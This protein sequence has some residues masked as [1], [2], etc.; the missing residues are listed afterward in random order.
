MPKPWDTAAAL[1]P[2]SP[3]HRW[4]NAAFWLVLSVAAAVYVIS[5]VYVGLAQERV[6]LS[7][8]EARCDYRV[9]LV[10][11]RLVT[12]LQQSRPPGHPSAIA[13]GERLSTLL[14][15]TQAMCSAQDSEIGRKIDRISAIFD[16][17]VDRSRRD[18]ENRQELLGL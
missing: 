2:P 13:A 3:S 5:G 8:T 15:E 7:R 16:A 4:I 12:L 14:H 17:Y 11:D 9:E 6:G 10:R 1:N 18:E